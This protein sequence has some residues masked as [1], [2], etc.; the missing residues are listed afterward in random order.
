MLSLNFSFFPENFSYHLSFSM[1]KFLPS[2]HPMSGHFKATLRRK[3][4]HCGLFPISVI[5]ACDGKASSLCKLIDPKVESNPCLA[6]SFIKLAA[7]KL[8]GSLIT[9]DEKLWIKR[10]NPYPQDIIASSMMQESCSSENI[11]V[12][13]LYIPG[14]MEEAVEPISF[15]VL[16]SGYYMDIIAQKLRIASASEVLISRY[17]CICL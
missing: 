12:R 6:L 10:L 16:P 8:S 13:A 1:L 9:P 2:Q 15:D 4:N 11:T 17:V 7:S 3:G 14:S 5:T